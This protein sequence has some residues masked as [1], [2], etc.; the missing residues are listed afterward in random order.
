MRRLAPA[1]QTLG[2]LPGAL[3]AAR[4][5]RRGPERRRRTVGG[6]PYLCFPL[7]RLA[8]LERRLLSLD[9]VNLASFHRRDHGPRD[10]GDLEAWIRARLREARLAGTADG[11]IVLHC[12]PRLLGR[13]LDGDSFWFCHDRAGML[14]AVL[15]EADGPAGAPRLQWL[16]HADG[17]PVAPDDW[18]EAVGIPPAAPPPQI[19]GCRYRF[20][21]AP[22]HIR[23]DC[24]GRDGA[25]RPLGTRL[26]GHRRALT[27]AA[28]LRLL[29]RFPIM[30]LAAVGRIHYQP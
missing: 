21:L 8:L 20:H 19:D 24:C 6:G 23:I 14:R 17:R 2:I 16:H 3:V 28:L 4:L 13:A 26:D 1:P 7:S 12:R 22:S 11:E 30:T 15:R 27:S 5:E 9:R 18:L 29:L 25:G 10:G